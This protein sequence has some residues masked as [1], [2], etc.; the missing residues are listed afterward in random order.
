MNNDV[1]Q[2]NYR[3]Y[4]GFLISICSFQII[5]VISSGVSIAQDVSNV[6]NIVGCSILL[7]I[8]CVTAVSTVT[9]L[10]LHTYLISQDMTTY[11]MIRDVDDGE[12]HHQCAGLNSVLDVFIGPRPPSLV[13]ENVSAALT[14]NSG[15]KSTLEEVSPSAY[16]ER[17]GVV[18]VV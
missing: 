3:Y 4:F 13:R 1:A 7:L 17:F 9:L 11:E 2:R 18:A 14:G 6:S 10:G 12:G 5:A 15:L 16:V 8:A